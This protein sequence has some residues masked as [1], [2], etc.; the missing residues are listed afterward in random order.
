MDDAQAPMFRDEAVRRY[1]QRRDHAA[2]PPYAAEPP[3]AVL[4]AVLGV[5]LVGGA[6]LL[7]PFLLPVMGHP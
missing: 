5:I 7:V 4:W 3:F 1:A 6:V 2:A